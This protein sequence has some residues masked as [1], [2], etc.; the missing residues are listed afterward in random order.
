MAGFC[1]IRLY[2]NSPRYFPYICRCMAPKGLMKYRTE[3]KWALIIIG[4][5]WLWAGAE[6]LCGL[7][8]EHI[9]KMRFYT[10][11][12]IV[13]F[14]VLYMAALIDKRRRDYHGRIVFKQ[15]FRSALGVTG[16]LTVLAPF[17]QYVTHTI[18]SPNF[19]DHA[20]AHVV[21]QGVLPEDGAREFFSLG[22]YIRQT[23][24]STPVFGL[25]I[26]LFVALIVPKIGSNKPKDYGN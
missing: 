13:P 12:F 23:M 6:R 11:F 14:V 18:I 21:A 5:T 17:T 4:A 19:F 26:S 8:Q 1:Q 7:H 15:G 2:V 25:L 20:I 22:N 3:I 10:N 16:L 24:L 9:E